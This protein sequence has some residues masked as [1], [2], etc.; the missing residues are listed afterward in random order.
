[1]ASSH[2]LSGSIVLLDID[3][4]VI[5]DRVAVASP[6]PET[7]IHDVFVRPGDR[8]SA[9]QKIA[10]VESPSVS[11][12]L[13]SLAVE[14]AKLDTNLA[15]YEARQA[16]VEA[17]L[18]EAEAASQQIK[19]SLDRLA[20]ANAKGIVPDKTLIDTL[21]ANLTTSDKLLSLRAEQAS[22]VKEITSQQDALRDV[23]ASYEA[24]KQ[25]YGGGILYA[26]ADGIV[27]SEVK[28]AGSV[29]GSGN[30]VIADIYTGPS[31]VLAYLP[32]SYAFSIGAGERVKI[33]A[34]SRW[35]VGTIQ[36][37]LPLTEAVPPEFQ[38]PTKVRARGQLVKVALPPDAEFP[39]GEKI[40]LSGCYFD[41][42]N[43]KP[44][45]VARLE[46][47]K[48]SVTSTFGYLFDAVGGWMQASR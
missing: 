32:S 40:L 14:K 34:A 7:R 2:V 5:R 43:A 26:P 27:S 21:S 30:A 44:G 15:G 33:R 48:K 29:L 11:S 22:L 19:I 36:S 20:K 23:T 12:Q 4:V 46:P 47:L 9:G 42:C 39:L 37:L 35:T 8:V 24:L 38:L 31:F 16:A 25:T 13:A 28:P 3:G 41:T 1:M 45:F 17:L 18:P 10:V 6:F